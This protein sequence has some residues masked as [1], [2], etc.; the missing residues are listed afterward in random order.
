MTQTGNRWAASSSW[1]TAPDITG[2][3]PAAAST[4]RMIVTR[5]AINNVAVCPE[6]FGSTGPCNFFR[7]TVPAAAT[8]NFTIDWEGTAGDPDVD[9]YHCADTVVAT[10]GTASD[11]CF[12]TGASGATGAKPQS[13]GAD[14]YA[15]G[16][17]WFVLEIFAGGGPRNAFVSIARP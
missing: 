14:A 4:S 1:Q 9:I 10:F 7:F 15:P 13:T 2:L 3:L 16:T 5:T 12:I 8:Y 6:G 17:Y 11:P